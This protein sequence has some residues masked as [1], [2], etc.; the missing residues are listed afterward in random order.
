MSLEAELS[1]GEIDERQASLAQQH[2]AR[3]DVPVQ[4]ADGVERAERRGELPQ[5]TERNSP[6]QRLAHSR[7]QVASRKV[8]HREE[9]V[10]VGHTEVVDARDVGVLEVRDQVVLPQEALERRAALDHVRHL[11]EDL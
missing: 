1:A 3:L 7:A 9:Y 2:V 6:M 8:L 5:V 10:I 4:Y 11:A